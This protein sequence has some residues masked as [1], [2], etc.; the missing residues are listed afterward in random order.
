MALVLPLCQYLCV[1]LRAAA[2]DEAS[3]HTVELLQ[4]ML[5]VTYFECIVPAAW[6]GM[7]VSVLGVG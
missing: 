7:L 6:L 4:A 3:I 1:T 5:I 2:S